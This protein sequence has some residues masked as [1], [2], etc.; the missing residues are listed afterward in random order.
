[1]LPVSVVSFLEAIEDPRLEMRVLYPFPEILL[2][3]LCGI[4]CGAEDFEEIVEAGNARLDLLQ[5]FFPFKHGIAGEKTFQ[6]AFRAI[7]GAAFEGL[8]RVWAESLTDGRVSGV[9]AF[10]GKTM[11]GSAD[12]ASGRPLHVLTAF[13]YESG[14]TL[15]QRS[16]SGRNPT[17]FPPCPRC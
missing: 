12:G 15:G 17:K 1:M 8:L 13:A 3:A 6:R 11:R 7:N 10:D 9:V 4:L 14:V 16:A 2:T 5:E